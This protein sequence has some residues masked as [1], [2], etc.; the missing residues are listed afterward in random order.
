M[1]KVNMCV[2]ECYCFFFFLGRGGLEKESERDKTL[3]SV[4]VVLRSASAWN[5]KKSHRKGSK[6]VRRAGGNK[7]TKHKSRLRQMPQPSK[8]YDQTRAEQRSKKEKKAAEEFIGFQI[9]GLAKQKKK[10][11]ETE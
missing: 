11:V 8:P 3:F 4:R 10:K 1:S 5:R 7:E 2:C 9:A 6:T